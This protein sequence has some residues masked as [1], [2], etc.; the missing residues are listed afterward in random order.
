MLIFKRL[1]GQASSG[2][3]VNRWQQYASLTP[4]QAN[5]RMTAKLRAKSTLTRQFG[6]KFEI[7]PQTEPLRIIQGPGF[8]NSKRRMKDRRTKGRATGTKSMGNKEWPQF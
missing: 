6:E 2:R 3:K 4:T 5:A 8:G 1:R 7:D